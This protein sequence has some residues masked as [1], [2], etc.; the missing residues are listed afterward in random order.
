MI[1]EV[2]VDIKNKQLNKSFDYLI[3][4]KFDGLIQIGM[5][6]YVPFGKMKRI[7]YVI[8]FKE[9]DDS[10]YQLKEIIDI[11]D[12]KRIL[13]E[14][15][16]GIAKYISENYFSYYASCL[17]AMIP[18]A[19]KYKYRKKAK[20]INKDN[21]STD[22]TRLFRKNELIIDNLK[23]EVL[24]L[25]YEEVKKNNI[26][27]D[28][29][30]KRI[31]DDDKIAYVRLI[32]PD[33]KTKSKKAKML[34]D[35]L[36]EAGEPVEKEIITSDL[37][38]KT[39][40]ITYLVDNKVVEL[41]YLEPKK[42]EK[43]LTISEEKT[44]NS[45]QETCYK[46]VEY[47]KYK[48]YLLHG[49]TSS[50]KT[51]LYMHWI[52]DVI[53]AGKKAI[54]L[55]PEISLTPQITSLFKARF[56]ENVA[57]IHSRLSVYEKYIEW[58]KII[59][60]E[61]KIVIGARSAIFAPIDNLGIIIIDEAHDSSYIQQNNPKY[62][63][64]DI[65][66][67][68]AKNFNIP[69]ILGSATPKVADY[70]KAI[71]GEY[72]LLVMKKRTNGLTLG[73][74]EVVDMRKE[75]EE[76]NKSVFSRKLLKEVKETY[77]RGEQSILFLNRR[78]FNSFVMCRSCGETVNCP[79]C[80]MALTYHKNSNILKCHH[81]GYT[82]YNVAKCP[83]C[84]S[85]KIR[86]VGSGTEKVVETLEREI[87][88]ARVLR[89]D[90]DT[91]SNMEDY[92]RFYDMFKNKEADIIVGTKMITKGLDFENV[93]L[94]GALN[95]SLSLNYPYY[96]ASEDTFEL[97]EQVSGRA[98]RSEKAGKCIIQAYNPEHYA[99]KYAARHNY[100]K[101]YDEEIKKRMLANL[102]PFS[103]LLEVLV[104]SEDVNLAYQEANKIKD[105]LVR[106]NT[107][108]EILGVSEDTIF[109]LKDRYRYKIEINVTD[110]RVLDELK[111]IYPLYQS[112]KD[113]EIQ[114]TRM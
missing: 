89:V 31:K 50:G 18:R 92:E 77:N 1:A 88:S 20:L 47:D 49:V 56:K 17:D 13:N 74:A 110:D 63:A 79:H 42:E 12:V 93:T 85:D 19:L 40:D 100:E 23:P 102:P 44:L 109:K 73:S 10:G 95:A 69:L 28:T 83:S 67:I 113:V 48:T 11:V 39:S 61:V 62:D 36:D 4:D 101:F 76:G 30:I 2:I 14:E 9:K 87:P 35:Y 8:G 3:P 25:I 103:M 91:T 51:E 46:K 57:I 54:L 82:T 81:C 52:K 64:K 90:M 97:I 108:S 111:A 105:K 7:G 38:Y 15:F 107:T 72:E 84:N 6:V 114:I 75:L 104:T 37:G 24:D 71:E 27:I 99:I 98:G 21:V 66:T 65:A 94:V 80:D 5:R 112:N 68:R 70:Y 43:D 29:E 32:N 26:I 86:F 22:L 60:N 41:F 78:G 58:K 16:V 96:D 55:V 106:L 59:D 53:E 45:E 34:I 33:F